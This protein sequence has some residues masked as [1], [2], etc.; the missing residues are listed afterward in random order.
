[1]KTT[2]ETLLDQ[3]QKIKAQ[4]KSNMLSFCTNISANYK[5]AYKNAEKIE[6]NFSKPENIIIAGMGG[7]AIGGDLFKDWAK[8]KI[9]VP[10]EVNRDYK[11]PQY[12][13]KKTLV[14]VTSYSGD[15]E[16]SLSAF[17]DALNRGCM[18]YCVSSGG[19][20]LKY[21][22]KLGVPNFMVEKGMPPRS[23]L[24]FMLMPL[25][26]L[27]EKLGL[28]SGLEAEA[29]EAFLVLKK[30]ADECS[31][32]VAAKDNFAKT[33]A[34]AVNGS[35]PTIYGFEIYR[36]I[37]QRYKQQFNENCKIAAKWEVFPE[38]DHNE[39]V[40]WEKSKDTADKF[41]VIFIKDK[42][43]SKAILSRI[44]ITKQIMQ[45]CGAK[46]FEVQSTGVSPLAKMLSVICVGDFVSVYLAVLRG[47][48]PTPVETINRLKAALGENKVRE[49]VVNALE[50]L[51]KK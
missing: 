18:V 25:L 20:L 42:A 3:P 9:K 29:A 19:A 48:D 27:A 15:T 40:G 16:E 6:V 24:P 26:V 13:G 50:K 7:S 22:E 17:L 30:C 47:V 39:I 46:M 36:A 38:L 4:D 32:D 23:A 41:S 10:I 2:N 12:A 8:D 14:L 33:L 34:L 1:M 44:E 31:P 51:A 45:G 11:L 5:K 37:A 43:A 35:I 49:E 21:A 28:V